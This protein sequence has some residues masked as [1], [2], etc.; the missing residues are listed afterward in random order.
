MKPLGNNLLGQ[1]VRAPL[2]DFLCI[3]HIEQI[4]SGALRAGEKEQ[5]RGLMVLHVHHG[6]PVLMSVHPH[7]N[8]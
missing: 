2:R 3:D 8:L 5:G 6:I 7:R 4:L 1:Y